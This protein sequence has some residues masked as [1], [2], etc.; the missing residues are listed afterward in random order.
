M[1]A[2]GLVQTHCFV[3]RIDVEASVVASRA[4]QRGPAGS[5]RP[6]SC[7]ELER[8]ERGPQDHQADQKA[9]VAHAVHNERL[10]GGVPAEW[11]ST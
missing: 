1:V 9:E 4:S 3:G 10:V 5:A 11:R 6:T 7:L 8:A 2:G